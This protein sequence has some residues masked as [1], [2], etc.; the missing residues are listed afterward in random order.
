M[1]IEQIGRDLRHAL[2]VIA[3]M[4]LLA[5]VVIISLGV[6]I[7]VNTTVFSWIQLFVFNPLPG[8]RGGGT[9]EL[10]EARAETGTYP[11]TSWTEYRDLRERLPAFEDLL[12]FR[13]LPVNVGETG[14]TERTYALLVSGNYFSALDIRPA[15]GRF[16]RPE[17]TS[18]P[19]GEPV[20]ILSHDY[21]QTRLGG[22]PDVLQKSIRVN[23]RDLVIVGVTPDGFQG[24]VLGLQF[25]LWMPAT[26]APAILPGTRELEDRNS[27]GYSVMGRLQRGA[28]RAEAQAQLEGVMR[29][30]ARTFP[31]TNATMTG[32]VLPFWQQPRGPQRMFLQG[33][34]LL[35]GVMLLLLLAVCGNT[36]NL[37]LARAS[38]RKR[39]IGIRLAIGAGPWRIARLLVIENLVLALAAAAVGVV[40]AIWGSQ[41]LRSVPLSTALPVKFQTSVD[42]LGLAFAALLGVCCAVVFGAAPALQLAR[43][44]PQLAL[45]SGDRT[46][47]R[48]R[49]RNILMAVEVALAVMVLVVAGLFLQSFRDTRSTDPGFR[50]EGVLLAAYDLSDLRLDENGAR[51]F[52]RRVIEKARA[53]PGVEMAS[54]AVSVPLDIHGMP[55][56]TFA[57]GGT[58]QRSGEARSCDQ[59]YRVGGLLPNPRHPHRTRA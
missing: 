42:V 36:A 41:A 14:Q 27:R 23:G 51:E 28:H 24:T 7:G 50:R 47:S 4:P 21:W 16:L 26:L 39:E 3:R 32:E 45:R 53:L 48:N 58:R 46:A 29:D 57:L 44:D 12:A 30:L 55:L 43:V 20:V 19:G 5:A 54:L 11:G 10:V 13:M 1:R 35:Q 18:R 15:L 2:R 9:F 25:D 17:E 40:V 31:A 52:A 33:L 34:L 49:L 8:V 6:G 37:L 22:A 59:Q 56:R 38:T